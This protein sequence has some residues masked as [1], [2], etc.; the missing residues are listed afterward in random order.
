[1]IS[2]AVVDDDQMLLDG[3]TAWLRPVEGLV[4]AATART[5]DQLLCQAVAR[6]DV[7]VLDLFLVDRSHPVENL[8]R[9]IAVGS[10]VLAVGSS[11]SDELGA[12]VLRAGASCYMTKDHDL[13]A[14]VAAAARQAG[15]QPVTAKNYLA[16]V[17]EK[18]RQ[19]GRPRSPSWI[20]PRECARPACR[21]QPVV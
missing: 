15:V 11:T 17:K 16:R 2:V 13:D 14:L 1:M 10:R 20:W 4:L 5:I 8:R 18:Y 3:I 19:A 9:L 7:V 21:A 6:A 12:Q